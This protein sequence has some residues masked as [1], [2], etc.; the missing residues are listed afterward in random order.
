[1]AK[2]N[3]DKISERLFILS[4]YKT[5]GTD[6]EPSENKNLFFDEETLNEA[7]GDEELSAE[8][9][10]LSKEL[11]ALSAA[12]AEAAA[13]T[14][15]PI[16]EPMPTE[17]PVAEPM[18][19]APVETNDSGEVEVDVSDIV[20]GVQKT[21]TGVQNVETKI[22]SIGSEVSEYIEKLMKSNETL[23]NKVGE[24][25]QNMKKEMAKRN[26]TPQEKLMLQSLHSFPYTQRLT[27]FWDDGD[28]SGGY[29][30][31]TQEQPEEDKAPTVYN[32][33]QKEIDDTYNTVDIRKTF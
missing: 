32:L 31:R 13:P 24:L 18:P 10:A 30:R 20:S 27:D 21:E 29:S 6:F 1:M 9:E 14:E 11:D 33:T 25:E 2:L 19:E 12:P 16:A 3:I 8:D 7:E 28:S 26:P 23:M 22:D 15:T 17:T 4:E 5:Y